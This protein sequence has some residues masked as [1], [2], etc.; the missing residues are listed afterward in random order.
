MIV[1]PQPTSPDLVHDARLAVPHRHRTPARN[2]VW[3]WLVV[4]VA[5]AEVGGMA[6]IVHSYLIAQTTVSG[7]AEFIWFWFGMICVEL[8]VVALLARRATSAAARS[9]LLVVIG[10]VTYAPKLLRDPGA[11]VYHDEFA[12]WRDTYDIIASGRLFQPAQIISI[13]A[14]YPGLHAATAVVVDITGLS[15][16]QAA[17]VLLL[18]CHV[19]LLLGIAALAR[20]I[21]LDSRAAALAAVA[22]GFNPSFLYFDTQF[23]Y[24]SMA[25]TLVVWTLAAFAQAI[26]AAG[27]PRRRAWCGLT[28]VLAFG[29][30]ITHHLS[31]IELAGVMA[32]VSAALSVPRLARSA[33]WKATAATAWGLTAFT[34]AAIVAWIAFVAPATIAY[35]SPYFG[36]GLS[37]LM[38]MA[39]GASSG[40][41]LFSASLSPG[42]EHLA[43]FGVPI[44]ALGFAVG[45]FFLHVARPTATR[46]PSGR[47]RAL[48]LAYTALGLVYFPSTVFILSPAGAEGARR[49]WAITW[50]G[51]AIVAGPVAAWLLDWTAARARRL[52]RGALRP[53][54]AVL[55]VMAL[56]GGTAA[57]L[58]ASYRFP[59]PY[60][61]GSDARSD[62]TELNA[63]TQ[64]FRASF[65]AGNNVVT[66]RF[67]GLIMGSY[68]LQDLADPSSGFPVWDLYTGQ[69]GQSLGPPFLIA[70]L[71]SSDYR[72][73]VVDKRMATDAPQVGVY[74]EGSEP[75]GFVLPDG[76]PIFKGRLAKFDG[77]RWMT[78]VF[79][80]DNYAVYR[81]D[82]PLASPA[83]QVGPAAFHGK[84]TVGR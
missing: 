64:W 50:I 71:T 34:G 35:L 14:R 74:F 42:W 65:G 38:N 28:A 72:Y 43:A 78:K 24:E 17:T 11:P 82:L 19:A 69:P 16:W 22:Y 23:A 75:D 54:L 37:Q 63:M 21:G 27:G 36:S 61:Y 40:R 5:A 66:D 29:C 81:M 1:E 30:V 57:G 55:A 8:P 84:L 32:L 76:Q 62:T 52:T 39:V 73:L 31:T 47:Q 2:T 18:L 15:T 45:G 12:H 53:A 59:G 83:Y 80:S 67:T 79:E 70:D 10:I 33:G 3:V 68:G 58:D 7:E 44:V 49:S 25:I 48:L 46:L 51:L 6:A 77:V 13:I 20:A 60:L 4:L 56:V 41:Q 26:R 9:A